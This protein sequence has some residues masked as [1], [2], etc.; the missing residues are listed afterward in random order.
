[1]NKNEISNGIP[2]TSVV[3]DFELSN[4]GSN[5]NDL[6]NNFVARDDGLHLMRS[7]REKM[8]TKKAHSQ[9]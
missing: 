3:A 4:L 8:I 6:A 2:N 5:A 9:E 1:M 7:T